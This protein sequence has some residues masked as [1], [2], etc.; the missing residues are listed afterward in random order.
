M[1]HI[2]SKKEHKQPFFFNFSQITYGLSDGHYEDKTYYILVTGPEGMDTSFTGNGI[3]GR[4]IWIT[5]AV[6]LISGGLAFTKTVS[7]SK[8]FAFI[9]YVLIIK[10]LQFL[11]SIPVR[12]HSAATL[13]SALNPALNSTL[14][15]WCYST[16]NS[17][18]LISSIY[19]Y[20]T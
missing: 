15:L 12:G 18:G 9:T 8:F 17:T 10:Q 7:R 6:A 13:N 3:Y 5:G 2:L 19:S 14:V 11:A 16:E 1:N 4:E 20:L